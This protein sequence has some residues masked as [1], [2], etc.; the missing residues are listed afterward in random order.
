VPSAPF[1]PHPPRRGSVVSGAS[2]GMGAAAA[3]ALAAAGH[4]VVL[5]ARRVERCEDVA[6]SIRAAGGEAHVHRLDLAEAASVEDFVRAAEE[7]VGP[8]DILVSSA[9]HAAPG[10]ALGTSPKDFAHT[11]EVNL[12]GAHRL[13]AALAPAMARRHHGDLVF[14]SSDII[15][16][17]RPLMA[18]Y[19]ASKWG[20]EGFVRALQLELEGTGVRATI[21]QPGQTLTEMGT[22]WG[23][24][25]TAAVLGEWVRFGVARHSHFLRP[26]AVAAAV[27]AAVTTPPGTHLPLIEVQPEGPIVPD[28][29]REGDSA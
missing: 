9:G 25:T 17:P 8:V 3:V 21:V 28:G 12:L 20:L 19:M 7:A 27:M 10:T 24:D 2:S 15:R 16:A 14:V 1:V 22:D 11:I 18:A 26:P 13:V 4:P 5:G 29:N 6:A 23:P